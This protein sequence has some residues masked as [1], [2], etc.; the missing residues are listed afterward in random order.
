MVNSITAMPRY[1][2]PPDPIAL[3]LAIPV[4][5]VSS[6]GLLVSFVVSA[7][8][9]DDVCG[10]ESWRRNADAW[11]WNVYLM[12]G[13]IAFI[14][15]VVLMICVWRWHPWGALVS[16]ITVAGALFVDLSWSE[17]HWRTVMGRHVGVAGL[18]AAALL[19]GLTAVLLVFLDDR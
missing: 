17:P 15:A 16:L 13:G 10:G 7:L 14:A 8:R 4:F 12:L 2:D 9:C 11:Q 5:V 6:L 1:R 18:C 19:A 3:L